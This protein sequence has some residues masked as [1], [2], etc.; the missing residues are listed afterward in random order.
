MGVLMITYVLSVSEE[1]DVDDDDD[2][3]DDDDLL[4]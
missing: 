1:E 3:G 4:G 2:D